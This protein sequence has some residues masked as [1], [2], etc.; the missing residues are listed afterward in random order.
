MVAKY[1][2]LAVG[3]VELQRNRRCYRSLWVLAASLFGLVILLWNSRYVTPPP[4]SAPPPALST[5]L[6]QA[7]QPPPPHCEIPR[8]AT[9][10][11]PPRCK[12]DGREYAVGS[13][14]P[15]S[16]ANCRPC[17]CT[18]DR[19][20]QCCTRRP[21]AHSIG[22]GT[23]RYAETRAF[24]A[25]WMHLKLEGV[26]AGKTYRDN[27]FM[28]WLMQHGL[29]FHQVHRSSWLLP[30][31]RQYLYEIERLLVSS[32]LSIR[33]DH[34]KLL[35]YGWP[36]AQDGRIAVG[37]NHTDPD[38]VTSFLADPCS[39]CVAIPYWHHPQDA[40]KVPDRVR[41][42]PYDPYTFGGS[43]KDSPDQCFDGSQFGR[44]RYTVGDW[45]KPQRALPNAKTHPGYWGSKGRCL[46]RPFDG[47]KPTP[48]LKQGALD[49]LLAR[50]GMPWVDW[51]AEYERQ[52][53]D[54]VHDYTLGHM[55]T[56]IS[57]LDPLFWLHH[58]GLDRGWTVWQS[59][60]G[61][62]SKATLTCGSAA[63][64]LGY[65]RRSPRPELWPKAEYPL[66]GPQHADSTHKV[67]DDCGP[68]GCNISNV[69]QTISFT[70]DM[71]P[72][73][74]SEGID[75]CQEYSHECHARLEPFSS[76]PASDRRPASL[77]SPV[78]AL[79][80]ERF[81][82]SCT[83]PQDERMC[84]CVRYEEPSGH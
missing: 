35:Q 7:N 71:P 60:C 52:V 68:K 40:R 76:W 4:I 65:Q 61:G 66:W 56:P 51:Q 31:H 79:D 27:L 74:G 46:R 16:A 29:W 10:L 44:G 69:H 26:P 17:T 43:G 55:Q 45:G 6:P 28:Q 9:G 25:A 34:E 84:D 63:S 53:H 75:E 49:A 41:V 22:R 20:W 18:S 42:A 81:L 33:C 8:V 37:V 30:W 23:R 13:Q 2:P 5:P 77:S 62:C 47:A 58:A 36:R 48:F 21:A 38:G 78:S 73:V 82:H 67:Y 15:K 83:G 1:N 59:Q 50:C 19:V 32:W 80:S 12:A 39:L 24:I 3:S 70:F 57:S 11:P 64:L 72:C 54:P 14:L